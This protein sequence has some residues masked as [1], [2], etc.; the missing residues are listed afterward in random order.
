MSKMGRLVLE[1]QTLKTE[2]EL[3]HVHPRAIRNVRHRDELVMGYNMVRGG[4]VS[5][6]ALYCVQHGGRDASGIEWNRLRDW[7]QLDSIRLASY[8][9][10]LEF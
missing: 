1:M 8:E 5:E 7:S 9:G 3:G 10:D 2:Q 4:D 6:W